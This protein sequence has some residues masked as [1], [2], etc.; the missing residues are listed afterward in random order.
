[1]CVGD[2]TKRSRAPFCLFKELISTVAGRF[3]FAGGLAIRK[4]V[5][6]QVSNRRRR[7]RSLGRKGRREVLCALKPGL[8]QEAWRRV[9]RV[10]NWL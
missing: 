9:V 10:G 4:V 1:M 2:C 5:D 6:V 8:V 3:G 7:K